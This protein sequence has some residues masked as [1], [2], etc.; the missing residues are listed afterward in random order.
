MSIVPRLS[1]KLLVTG[2]AGFIGGNFSRYIA[3]AQPYL[4][5]LLLD[6]LTRYSSM[7]P[8]NALID[9]GRARF[10]RLDLADATAVD[11]LI[12]D[13]APD[14]TV[15]FAAESHN[16][17][18]IRD[19]RPFIQSNIVGAFN[20]LESVRLKGHGR[21]VHISTIEVYGEQ[22]AGI[23]YF[24]EA[25]PLNAKTP[26]SAAKAAADLLV[27]S[28]MQTYP[29]LD[30]AMTHCANNY[31]PWQFPEK[32]IPL[33]ITNILRG[34]RVPLYGDGRQLRDWLHVLDHCRG[35]ELVLAHPRQPLPAEAATDASLLPIYDFSARQELSNR[36]I[37][38]MVTDALG[39]D[40]DEW[41]ESVPDRPNHD[42]RYLIEPAKA[43]AEL[44]F[45][46]S[47][48]LSE[49]IRE[50]VNWY[51]DNECWWRELLT[52]GE[53]QFD[54]SNVAAR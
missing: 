43:E 10:V 47:I 5:L 20:L 6:K 15:N 24:T 3:E 29:E 34:R 37:I 14:F 49:G 32:L 1:G 53:L 18:A 30:V 46:P 54:W 27:R 21:L 28:H 51:R 11:S 41:T 25:S 36:S 13:E 9:S 45:R 8:I 16:D 2:A 52:R 23:P 40:F 38:R 26:Y 4:E 22:V 39:V 12:N 48:G 44:G 31:G 7:G 19:S 42:R 35:I 17:R 33:A 50:T